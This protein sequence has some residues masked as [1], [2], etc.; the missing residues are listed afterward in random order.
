MLCVPGPRC[1][2]LVDSPSHLHWRAW[3]HISSSNCGKKTGSCK[4]AAEVQ[5]FLSEVV[6]V[7]QVSHRE[8][9]GLQHVQILGIWKVFLFLAP[10]FFLLALLSI[11]LLVPVNMFSFKAMCLLGGVADL[12]RNQ[13]AGRCGYVHYHP[14]PRMKPFLYLNQ[15]LLRSCFLFIFV[16]LQCLLPLIALFVS[17]CSFLFPF[18]T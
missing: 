6:L 18:S 1:W 8:R 7:A 4:A 15:S 2:L 17:L 16:A 13:S 3:L 5:Q 9:W 14:P 12:K 10:R 11:A